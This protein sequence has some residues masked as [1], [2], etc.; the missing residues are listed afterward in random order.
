MFSGSVLLKNK[1]PE[2]CWSFNNRLSAKYRKLFY[3]SYGQHLKINCLV[4]TIIHF[5]DKSQF[6]FQMPPV[7]RR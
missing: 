1:A 6:F 5:K 4:K 7:K 2:L 3:D